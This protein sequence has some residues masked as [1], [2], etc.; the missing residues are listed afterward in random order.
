MSEEI[1]VNTD[2]IEDNSLQENIEVADNK[3]INK[4]NKYFSYI[5]TLFV[6]FSVYFILSIFFGYIILSPVSV[7]GPSM[8]PTL[9]ASAT[10]A[11]YDKNTDVVYIRK[12]QK[13]K[14]Q[15]IVMFSAANLGLE[16]IYDDFDKSSYFIK[17]VIATEGD[18]IQF[19]AKDE[20]HLLS[21]TISYEL[22]VNG[23]Y[24]PEPYAQEILMTVGYPERSITSS[25]IPDL[26]MY[27]NLINEV[28]ITVP[29]GKVFVMGDNRPRSTDSRVFGF[30]DVSDITG[31]VKIHFPYGSNIVYSIYHSIKENY[32][33]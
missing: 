1:S 24:Q 21:H 22:Y 32:L 29:E 3:T 10:G 9:N 19:V 4:E 23:V 7:E 26:E 18:T 5:V 11:S 17:R 33:F 8:Y 6:V 12:T 14:K 15:D 25:N 20:I 2:K 31:V 27:N 28:V 13:V 30:V 16:K